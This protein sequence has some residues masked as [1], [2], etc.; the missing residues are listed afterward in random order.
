MG[1]NLP[2]PLSSIEKLKGL[3]DEILN[4]IELREDLKVG[5]DCVSMSSIIN[6]DS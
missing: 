1:K 4:A 6:S 5:K 2:E 3:I